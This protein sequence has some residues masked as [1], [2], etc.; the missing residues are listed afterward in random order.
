MSFNE[1]HSISLSNYEEWFILYMDDELSASQKEM[2]DQFLLLHPHLQEEMDLLLSTKLPTDAM[3][4][5]DKSSLKASAM[6]LN[7]VDESLLLYIDNELSPAE[8]KR[9]EEKAQADDVLRQQLQLLRKTKLDAADGSITY[10]DKTELYRHT[11]KVVVLFPVWMRIA[12]AVILILFATLFFLNNGSDQ[13][14]SPNAGFAQTDEPIKPDTKGQP[15]PANSIRDAMQPEEQPVIA[16]TGKNRQPAEKRTPV[17]QPL[18]PQKAPLPQ[19]LVLPV[20]ED[21]VET[22]ALAKMEPVKTGVSVLTN[23]Q[24]SALNK[25]VANPTVTSATLAS[26]NPIESPEEPAV[27]EGDFEPKRSSA[28]GFLRKVTRFLER[29]TGIGTANADNEILVGAVALKLN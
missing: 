28:K 4:F 29:R 11:E 12:V 21:G 27:T 17:L 3:V 13:P 19:Q 9:V 25:I 15:L 16:K 1:N 22:A 18:A 20:E 5:F 8:R 26:Y 7:T 24:A 10:P 23:D 6:K 14:A 2:V